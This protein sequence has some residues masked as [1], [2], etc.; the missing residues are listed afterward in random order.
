MADPRGRITRLFRLTLGR[1]PQPS[2]W[3][4]WR[5]IAAGTASSV[6]TTQW[7]YGEW[8]EAGRTLRGFVPFAH[9]GD[10]RWQVFATVAGSKWHWLHLTAEGGHPGEGNTAPVR[11]WTAPAAG[12]V[13]L[14]GTLEH[15]QPQG[16]GVEAHV[17]SSRQ[18]EVGHWVAEH[19]STPTHLD[20]VEVQP[21]D[22][23]DFVV[24]NRNDSSFDAF[25]WAPRLTP[26]DEKSARSELGQPRRIP[27]TIAR[28]PGYVGPR[29]A[30]AADVQ[31]VCVFGLSCRS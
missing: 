4:P 22:T 7:G 17:I 20:R 26:A 25:A 12:V 15:P 14:D 8:D 27:W 1:A 11:R 23:L 2:D 30:G 3:M 31:R 21:G 16:N 18:G 29:G 13:V 10:N 19:N 28:A 6:P 9:W 5:N 24:T